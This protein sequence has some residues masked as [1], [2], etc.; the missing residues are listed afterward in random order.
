[1]QIL[2]TLFMVAALPLHLSSQTL[3]YI[4]RLKY[5]DNLAKNCLLVSET[6]SNTLHRRGQHG[7]WQ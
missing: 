3:T 7:N 6:Q 1:M 5:S 2:V 4:S